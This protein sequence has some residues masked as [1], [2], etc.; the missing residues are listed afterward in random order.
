M[1]QK[2]RKLEKNPLSNTKDFVVVC[3]ILT[4][5]NNF[6]KAFIYMIYILNTIN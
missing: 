6:Q 1:F 2:K 4:P 3:I 5:Q